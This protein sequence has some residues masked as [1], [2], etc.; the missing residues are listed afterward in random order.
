VLLRSVLKSKP[1]VRRCLKRCWHCR[2]FFL[3]HRRNCGRN[4]LG[5][6]F[7]CQVTHRKRESTRRSVAYYQDPVGKK[8]KRDLNQRRRRSTPESSTPNEE[9]CLEEECE[10]RSEPMMEH[11][12][13]VVGLIEGRP[14][15]RSQILRLLR[16]VLRQHRMARVRRIDQII[17]HLNRHPP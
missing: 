4:K 16:K 11:L 2:I 12:R 15:S 8:K 10:P 3:T 9:G 5:C 7:G 1:D 14:I 6:P 17:D 13:L